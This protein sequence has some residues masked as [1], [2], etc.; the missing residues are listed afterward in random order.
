MPN[1]V[2]FN[3]SKLPIHV[4]ATIAAKWRRTAK[5][6]RCIFGHDTASD[7]S[8]DTSD[9]ILC[10][11][12]RAW[13]ADTC[14]SGELAPLSRRLT[15]SGRQVRREPYLPPVPFCSASRLTPETVRDSRA[16]SVRSALPSLELARQT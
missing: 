6:C 16:G 10:L 1:E 7:T 5:K 9:D 4:P 2:T 14:V 8:C 12:L 3:S 13:A 15:F 11:R